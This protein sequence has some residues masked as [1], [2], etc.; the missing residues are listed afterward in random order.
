[1]VVTDSNASRSRLLRIRLRRISSWQPCM[2]EISDDRGA[3]LARLPSS[4]LVTAP[5][6]V[7]DIETRAGYLFCMS[8]SREGSLIQALA[9]SLGGVGLRP[10]NRVGFAA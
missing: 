3:R 6:P 9:G 2:Q 4:R 1:M 5:E 10:L 7:E 8:A